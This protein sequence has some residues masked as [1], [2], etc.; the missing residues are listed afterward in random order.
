MEGH[1]YTVQKL[2]RSYSVMRLARSGDCPIA[3][4]LKVESTPLGSLAETILRDCGCVR[5]HASA[6]FAEQFLRPLTRSS[7]G[8]VTISAARLSAWAAGETA[9]AA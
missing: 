4:D 8:V 7:H 9:T 2:A 1:A 6:A 3:D 5:P